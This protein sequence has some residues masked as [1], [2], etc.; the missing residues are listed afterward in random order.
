MNWLARTA[1]IFFCAG[2]FLA[3]FHLAAV[4]CDRDP[5]EGLV[6]RTA[7]RGDVCTLARHLLQEWRARAEAVGQIN[8]LGVQFSRC[9]EA[10]NRTDVFMELQKQTIRLRG[11]LQQAVRSYFGSIGSSTITLVNDPQTAPNSGLS[12]FR[13]TFSRGWREGHWPL[14]DHAGTLTVVLSIENLGSFGRTRVCID[15][16]CRDY[17]ESGESF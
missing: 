13:Y 3:P 4:I 9:T 5:I 1:A 2:S 17:D 10:Q 16:E 6:E 15:Q 7:F 8:E 14:T 12:G 11:S